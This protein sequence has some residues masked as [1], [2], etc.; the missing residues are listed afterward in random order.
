MR[1]PPSA[2]TGIDPAA[3]SLSSVLLETRRSP[4][5]D[6]GLKTQQSAPSSK[7][8]LHVAATQAISGQSAT[9][10]T[11]PQTDKKPIKSQPR[12]F[13]NPRLLPRPPASHAFRLTVLTKLHAELVRLNQVGSQSSDLEAKT[14]GLSEQDMIKLAL[15]EEEKVAREE[16]LVYS[17]VIKHRITSFKKMAPINWKRFLEMEL[18]DAA[19]GSTRRAAATESAPIETGLRPQEGMAVLPQ[20]VTPFE[21]LKKYGF[22]TTI[23]SQTEVDKVKGAVKMAGGYEECDRCKTRFQIFP[24]R[25]EEDGALTT[26]GPCNYHYGKPVAPSKS[27]NDHVKG[28]V[29]KRYTCCNQPIGSSVGCT[30]GESHVV[31]FTDVKRLASILQF[32]ATPDNA[33]EGSDQPLCLDC[34][35]CYTVY[36]LEVARM[37]ATAWPGGEEVLD[38]LVRPMGEVLDLNTRFS[39]IRAE[40]LANAKA[41][42]ETRT[43]AP[44]HATNDTMDS[45]MRIVASPAAARALLFSRLSPTT[46]I[47]GHG[48][49][50]DLNAVRIIHPTVVDTALLPVFRHS[51]GL[52]FRHGLKY[53]VSKHLDRDIQMDGPATS[54][55]RSTKRSGPGPNGTGASLAG[56]GVDQAGDEADT[57]A[58]AAARSVQSRGHDSKEDARAAGDLVWWAAGQKWKQ[59]ARDGATF[60]NDG[61]GDHARPRL[62]YR[63]PSSLHR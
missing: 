32:E 47:I 60:T 5:N 59:M 6:K 51:R 4:G 48:L 52:P 62:V 15:D 10:N 42:E 8:M 36:G 12:E 9:R 57:E 30:K 58:A 11:T 23:P 54:T 29:E 43:G 35:M 45:E 18:R 21:D 49:E 1:D 28:H 26:G 13:L 33:A 20:L 16:P 41:Y 53:L 56:M 37:T 63:R 25:R 39:G 27:P 55:S 50:N 19:A 14:K 17:N 46:P 7:D 3:S 44:S 31:K 34:E 2:A 24:G 61:D 38:V 40:Q 22:V